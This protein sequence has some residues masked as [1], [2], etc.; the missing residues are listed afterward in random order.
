MTQSHFP[1]AYSKQFVSVIYHCGSSIFSSSLGHAP[2]LIL[3]RS[4]KQAESGRKK[5]FRCFLL[6]FISCFALQFFIFTVRRK[7]KRGRDK[8]NCALYNLATWASHSLLQILSASFHQTVMCNKNT[9]LVHSQLNEEEIPLRVSHI[10]N[11]S[12]ETWLSWSYCPAVKSS[13]T[14]SWIMISLIKQSEA[15]AFGAKSLT[16]PALLK[17]LIR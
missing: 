8:N 1:G 5:T 9:S 15:F 17:L 13:A 2:L 7:W 3:A 14:R 10:W 6:I 4:K 16:F 12:W 11:V